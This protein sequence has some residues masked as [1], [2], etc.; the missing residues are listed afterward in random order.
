M[1]RQGI[2]GLI[3]AGLLLG[4]LFLF[5]RRGVSSDARINA[6]CKTCGPDNISITP[7]NQPAHYK[8]K[9]TRHI[10][11]ND[12]GMPTLIEI[13]RDYTIA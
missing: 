10:E 1:D 4:G 13:T 5:A 8:N 3:F 6:P 9:E 11:Y 2:I 7:I 12:A